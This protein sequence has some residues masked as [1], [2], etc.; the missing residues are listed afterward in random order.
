MGRDGRGGGGAAF[1][2]QGA[3]SVGFALTLTP[4]HPEPLLDEDEAE[5]VLVEMSAASAAET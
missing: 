5:S 2:L 1:L 3:W 4:T